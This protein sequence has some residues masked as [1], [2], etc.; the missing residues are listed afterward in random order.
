MS[1]TERTLICQDCGQE[2]IFTIG[3]QEFY[4][5]KGF[6]NEPKRCPDCRKSR[7][8]NRGGGGSR[9]R[10]MYTIVCDGCG[11]EAQ[12]PFEPREGR[13]VYCKNCFEQHRR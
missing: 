8:M 7:K 6:Q 10:R 11:S 2:F 3:E 12:V 4:Q 13:P 9:E 1:L 5:E